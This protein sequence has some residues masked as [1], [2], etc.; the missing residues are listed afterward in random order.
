MDT[1]LATDVPEAASSPDQKLIL[2]L[3]AEHPYYQ[4]MM[5]R[6]KEFMILYEGGQAITALLLKHAREHEEAFK[7]R[8][9]RSFYLNY[10]R[11]ILDTMTDFIFRRN[12]IIR[13]LKS[14]SSV[15]QQE[16]PDELK[17]F[18]KDVDLAGSSMNDFM[19]KVHQR[20]NLF[21]M[22]YVA[23]DMP[24][25]Q[26]AVNTEYQRKAH[27][28]RPYSYV[29]DPTRVTNWAFDDL[30]QLS[31]IR[32]TEDPPDQEDALASRSTEKVLRY[33]TW[34]RKK[35]YLHEVTGT[36]KVQQLESADHTL[37]RVPV[38]IVRMRDSVIREEMGT[39]L[40]HDIAPLNKAIYQ[41]TSLLDEDLYQKAM[42]LL[43]V[44]STPADENAPIVIS[45][46]NVLEYSG[47]VPP[48]FIS[49]SSMPTQMILDAITRIQSE[50]FRMAKVSEQDS[51]AG[52]GIAK[53]FGFNE[54]NQMLAQ[55]ADVLE[56]AEIDIH[57]V[58]EL[59]MNKEWTGMIDYPEEF[60]VE[61][62]QD[63]LDVMEKSTQA[64]LSDRFKL[65]MQA[66]LVRKFLS[67]EDEKIIQ[68]II[69]EIK[70]KIDEMKAE[71]VRLQQE[72]LNNPNRE[73]AIDQN[74]QESDSENVAEQ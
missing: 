6:W 17:Q 14:V 64:I 18:H 31:W 70:T 11:P 10:C 73:G 40:M 12:N 52:T 71:Q 45:S 53:A 51:G 9:K 32:W 7:D 33:R 55:Q 69:D 72:A 62:F 16:L 61:L 42:N 41:W 37:G 35:W 56:R 38:T 49:P 59:W 26:E 5:P 57:R 19:K 22:C 48:S 28:V 67:K 74:Q 43:V 58:H 8:Q 13:S 63:E 2:A 23:V 65:L 44:Q 39:S 27:N 15:D 1:K 60:G 50:I 21:G 25:K 66:R 20:A 3:K 30:G 24:P 29:I 36:S 68:S 4:Y 46:N 34:T 54:T 47:T